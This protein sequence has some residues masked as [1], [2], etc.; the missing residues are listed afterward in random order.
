M[1]F[2]ND[3]DSSEGHFDGELNAD[4]EKKRRRSNL[5]E[6]RI[7]KVVSYAIQRTSETHKTQNN[8]K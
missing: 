2:I 3:I 6:G 5:I 8:M 4:K 7:T 1:L